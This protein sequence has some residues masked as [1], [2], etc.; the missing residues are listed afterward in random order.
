MGS[1]F[2]QNM[3]RLI[4]DQVESLFSSLSLTAEVF[5]SQ[6]SH[7]VTFRLVRIGSVVFL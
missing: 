4:L 5:S 6:R 3:M 2:I 1:Q 7:L